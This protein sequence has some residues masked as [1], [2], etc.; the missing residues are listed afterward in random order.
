MMEGLAE[1]EIVE[2][3]ERA[4]EGKNQQDFNWQ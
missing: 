3:G 1:R 2:N 4:G